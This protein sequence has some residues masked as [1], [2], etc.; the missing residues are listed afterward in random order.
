VARIVVAG[1]MLRH[2]V[3]G[4]V[5]AYMHYVMGFARLGHD[6]TY[7]EESGW[8]G[9]AYDPAARAWSDHPTSGLRIVRE[10]MARE[11]V[12]ASLYFV[13]RHTGDIDGGT[14]AELRDRLRDAD[15]LLNV[16]GVCV[17]P[18][19]G[20]CRRRAL[21]DL[22]PVFTQ[23]SLFGSRLLD[24]YDALFSYGGNIGR[25]GCTIPTRGRTW[26]R[27]VPPVVTDIWQ[28]GPPPPDG[29]MTTIGNWSAYGPVEVDGEA[30]GQKDREFLRLADLPARASLPLHLGLSGADAGV[31]R[32]LG[33]RGWTT[34]D[35]GDRIGSDLGSY[36]ALIAS[37]RGE[38]SAAKHAYVKSRSG[39]FS[40]RTVCYLA[41]GRPAVVQNTGFTDWLQEDD[42]VLAFETVEEALEQLQRVHDDYPRHARAAREV[43]ARVFGHDRV[44]PEL[45][46]R[47]TSAMDARS[48][49]V[50][51]SGS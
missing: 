14:G 7:V 43:A 39:W 47:A 48:W 44:L 33:D 35:A 36:R 12:P 19:F 8:P 37:S 25:P 34:F 23:A 38:F 46:D 22:D 28:L 2:P 24:E 4:N 41:A 10:L 5:M 6:V 1:Y 16:G 42:G 31:H 27:A 49:V 45:L 13:E 21:V 9:S 40:D 32:H 3:P 29:P 26:M 20:L 30:Y 50:T 18:E 17:L 11:R 51:R 15:L